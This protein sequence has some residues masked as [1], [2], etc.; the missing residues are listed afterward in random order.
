M[1]CYAA[2]GG[3][4]LAIR[5]LQFPIADVRKVEAII[6]FELEGEI[7]SP[8]EE[9]VFDYEFLA[10]LSSAGERESGSR[11]LAAA[12]AKADVAQVLAQFKTA[13]V[14]PRSLFA[15]PLIYRFIEPVAVEPVIADAVEDPTVATAVSTVTPLAGQPPLVLLVD[16][17]ASRTNLV[18]LEDGRPVFARTVLRGG[19][20]LTQAL[21]TA[22]GATWEQSEEAKRLRGAVS[23][24]GFIPKDAI[25]TRMGE[26]LR[27]ALAPLVRDIRQTLTSYRSSYQREVDRM[28]LVGGGAAQRG[29]A[30]SLS[31]E[32]GLVLTNL[33][34]DCGGVQ[35]DTNGQNLDGRFACLLYTSDAADE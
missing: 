32:L 34:A 22:F 29:L 25:E 24:A 35:V 10:R 19:N 20:E 31:E 26:V 14:Q 13:G 1:T 9:V 21:C 7:V 18:V 4:R 3:D 2:L 33:E 8:L 27:G 11:V 23:H 12:A 30:E 5:R 6:P 15:G 17:G 16:V 28:L